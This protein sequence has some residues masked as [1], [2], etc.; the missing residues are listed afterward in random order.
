MYIHT[1]TCICIHTH[2]YTHVHAY[3]HIPL[4]KSDSSSF[5]ITEATS[6]SV[7]PQSSLPHSYLTL[8]F[9]S[10]RLHV[11]SVPGG[12][13]LLWCAHLCS[14]STLFIVSAQQDGPL[15]APFP[16]FHCILGVWPSIPASRTP[17]G[18]WRTLPTDS[19]GARSLALWCRSDVAR[20]DSGCH[21]PRPG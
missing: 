6:A 3:T 20:C 19:T 7:P 1:Y 18:P 9:S 12:R 21:R 15:L 5:R 4:K 11:T 2:V 17:R 13:T 8:A 10:S 14:L 16:M